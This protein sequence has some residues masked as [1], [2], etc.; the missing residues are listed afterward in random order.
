MIFSCDSVNVVTS[1]LL[2]LLQLPESLMENVFCRQRALL[3]SPR[4][5]QE[6]VKTCDTVQVCLCVPDICEVLCV[7]VCVCALRIYVIYAALVL[8]EL[9]NCNETVFV[10]EIVEP[11]QTVLHTVHASL[12]LTTLSRI[13]H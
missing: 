6:T 1:V 2:Y 12:K 7:C 8:W 9:S 10:L 11:D 13:L 5:I 4:G 3:T